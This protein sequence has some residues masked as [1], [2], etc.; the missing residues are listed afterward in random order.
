MVGQM[1]GAI[2]GY[3]SI[4]KKYIEQMNKWDDGNFSLRGCLLFSRVIIS[5]ADEN[6]SQGS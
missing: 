2:Y 4:N 6:K 1:A 3:K 5:S